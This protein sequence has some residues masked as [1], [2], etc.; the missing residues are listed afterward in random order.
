MKKIKKQEKK[1][2][3]REKLKLKLELDKERKILQIE[4]EKYKKIETERDAEQEKMEKSGASLE[5]V[6]KF[7]EETIRLGEKYN[8][9]ANKVYDLRVIHGKYPEVLFNIKSE[10]DKIRTDEEKKAS[11]LKRQAKVLE[12]AENER[13]K[14]EEEEKKKE[15]EHVEMLKKMSP[16]EH[17]EYMKKYKEDDDER[18]RKGEEPTAVVES[19]QFMGNGIYTMSQKY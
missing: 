19:G 7:K 15:R 14:E 13:K 8:T 11:R 16:D 1:R 10:L 9:L 12:K 3:N 18:I 2:L 17:D 4:K 5:E 6:Q